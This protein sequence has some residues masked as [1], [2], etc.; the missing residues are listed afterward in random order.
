MK[1]TIFSCVAGIRRCPEHPVSGDWESIRLYRFS[2]G[3]WLRLMGMI[4]ACGILAPTPARAVPGEEEDRAVLQLRRI[5]TTPPVSALS[6]VQAAAHT[7]SPQELAK[8]VTASMEKAAEQLQEK[9]SPVASQ[10]AAIQALDDLLKVA[11]ERQQKSNSDAS[12]PSKSDAS[13]RHSSG[14]TSGGTTSREGTSGETSSGSPGH[15]PA[16][17]APHDG[18]MTTQA[19]QPA[20]N[21]P[22]ARTGENANAAESESTDRRRAQHAAELRRQAKLQA[23]I[24]GHLPPAV[25]EQL[26]NSYRERTLPQYEDLV[27]SYYEALATPDDSRSP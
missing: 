1:K 6:V 23:D 20:T 5:E 12:R 22:G 25:R 2:R 8:A 14:G 10:Q 4:V 26:L 27:R 7:R 11:E 21:A 17:H 3:R 13:A 19:D 24:W 16:G 18:T 15:T 9:T